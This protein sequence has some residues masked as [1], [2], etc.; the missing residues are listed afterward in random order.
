MLLRHEPQISQM[1]ADFFLFICDNP[2]HLRIKQVTDLY[3]AELACAHQMKLATFDAHISH[4]AAEI[5][6]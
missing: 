3:L 4:R 5:I 1:N 6:L 2:R